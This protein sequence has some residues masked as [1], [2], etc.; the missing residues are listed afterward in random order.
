MC[1]SGEEAPFG[2]GVFSPRRVAT[3]L[4]ENCDDKKK[5]IYLFITVY[6]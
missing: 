3:R 4:S 2:R 6:L 1:S 5:S